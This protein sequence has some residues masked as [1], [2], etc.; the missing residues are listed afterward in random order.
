VKIIEC[1]EFFLNV[2][3]KG[4]SSFVYEDINFYHIKTL[5]KLTKQLVQELNR[6]QN[7]N[8][9][10]LLSTGPESMVSVRQSAKI[11]EFRRGLVEKC[12]EQNQNFSFKQI[13]S[14]R[15]LQRQSFGIQQTDASIDTIMEKMRTAGQIRYHWFFLQDGV[16]KLIQNDNS[17]LDEDTIRF[18]ASQQHSAFKDEEG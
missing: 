13:I 6:A 18:Y 4:D 11:A 16:L 8:M 15:W 1:L 2:G 7:L 9:T 12:T 17:E 5:L 10:T 3:N 14:V